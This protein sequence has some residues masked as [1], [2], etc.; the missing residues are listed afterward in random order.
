MADKKLET[1]AY[2]LDDISSLRN[3]FSE[4]NFDFADNPVNK[5]NWNDDEDGDDVFGK[6]FSF[7]ELE[8]VEEADG[9][10]DIKH[11]PNWAK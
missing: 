9:N 5:D 8:C 3:L 6:F 4:L 1:L 2:R 10:Q 7:V 11:T